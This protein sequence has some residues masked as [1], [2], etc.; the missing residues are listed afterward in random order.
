LPTNSR[1]G[2]EIFDDLSNGSTEYEK[3][4]AFKRA[5]EGK[6]ARMIEQLEPIKKASVSLT[7]PKRTLFSQV[8][9]PSKASIALT[10][11]PY[12]K[13]N[14]QQIKGIMNLVSYYVPNCKPENVSL[15]DSKG[16][17]LNIDLEE[18]N[19]VTS[20]IEKQ[21]LIK[22]KQEQHLKN[23]IE[24]SLSK[25]L[26]F[27]RFATEI[28]VEMNF[29]REEITSEEYTT[30]GFEPIKISEESEK[31]KFEGLGYKQSGKPGVTDNIPVYKGKYNGPIKYE[32]EKQVSN[33]TPNKKVVTKVVNPTIKRITVT[34]NVDGTYKVIDKNPNNDN[35]PIKREYI[36]VKP[37]DIEKIRESV[38][39]AVGFDEKRNDSINVSEL[40]FDRTEEFKIQNKEYLN[41][42]KK[43]RLFKITVI[44]ILT[45]VI[46]FILLFELHKRWK[47]RKEELLRKRE[48]AAQDEAVGSKL[49]LEAELTPEEREKLE[50]LKNAQETAQKDP[51]MVAALLRTWLLEE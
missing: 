44:C 41:Q 4:I 49:L 10:L 32:S 34:V 50:L 43:Q 30:T 46:L 48:L 28:S 7:I 2:F 5:S 20:K 27:N 11:N 18:E 16:I 37:E 45:L 25:I 3:H 42:I 15:I 24:N 13:L 12:V 14:R 1:V 21:N 51:E 33:Y 17:P 36:H 39:R 29:D 22:K 38:K 9:E 31:E 19:S 35:D 47:L 8:E 23:K 6:L 26:S 40:Q